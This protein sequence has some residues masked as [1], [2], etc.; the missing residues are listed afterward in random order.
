LKTLLRLIT[1][2]GIKLPKQYIKYLPNNIE[3]VP[4]LFFNYN[5]FTKL[6][7]LITKMRNKLPK[8][9]IIYLPNDHDN[10]TNQYA[11]LPKREQLVLRKQMIK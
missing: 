11:K 3:N 10:I 7:Q 8:Q 2:M 9:Y 4:N 6:L 5:L 1:K